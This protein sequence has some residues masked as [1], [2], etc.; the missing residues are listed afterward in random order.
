MATRRKTPAPLAHQ[1]ETIRRALDPIMGEAAP[2]TIDLLTYCIQ[3]HNTHG[4]GASL[5]AIAAHFREEAEQR[6]A[7]RRRTT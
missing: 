5:E 6:K 2:T 7:A 3:F 4:R 1:I